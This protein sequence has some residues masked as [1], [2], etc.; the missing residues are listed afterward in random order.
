MGVPRSHLFNPSV[1]NVCHCISH[2]VRRQKLL[3][4]K[5]RRAAQMTRMRTLT[6]FLAVDVLKQKIAY[7]CNRQ[8]KV[9]GHF[10][11]GRF[12][13]IIALDEPA[14]IAHMVYV[15]LNLVRAGI[16]KSLHDSRLAT[17]ADA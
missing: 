3:G 5:N 11:E 7:D 4:K 16:A 17:I 14:I 1:R 6:Q 15:A 13:S 8:D 10:W 2:C 12:K 9:T